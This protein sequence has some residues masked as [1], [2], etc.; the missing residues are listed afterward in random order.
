MGSHG[1]GE[2]VT[3]RKKCCQAD[4]YS[5]LF[6]EKAFDRRVYCVTDQVLSYEDYAAGNFRPDPKA[7][8]TEK[9]NMEVLRRGRSK[10]VD[11][12][13]DCL[14]RTAPQKRASI[15][16]IQPQ[17]RGVFIALQSGHLKALHVYVHPSSSQREEV[18]ETYTYKVDYHKDERTSRSNTTVLERGGTSGVSTRMATCA[19]QTTLREIL[20]GCSGLPEL[21]GTPRHHARAANILMI[22]YSGTLCLY[23]DN[24][25]S[26]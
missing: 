12:F 2:R 11:Y 25:P 10:R 15:T 14:V 1:S 13:L 21:P 6:A 17:E 26:G 18:I 3:L 9:T 16:L 8:E 5:A 4:A 23:E 22:P 7:T 19:L 20:D 24:L